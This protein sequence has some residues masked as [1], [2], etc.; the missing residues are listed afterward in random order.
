[1]PTAR[2]CKSPQ[3]MQLF[4]VFLLGRARLCAVNGRP[5]S[6]LTIWCGWKNCE[7]MLSARGRTSTVRTIV[8]FEQGVKFAGS[9]RAYSFHTVGTVIR[10]GWWALTLMSPRGNEQRNS[11][12]RC[13]PSSTLGV[14][15]YSRQLVRSPPTPKDASSS[16]DDFVAALDSRIRSMASTH[17]LLSSS[18]WQGVPLR[19]LLQRELAPYT[20]NSNTCIDGPE[21]I[22]RPEAAQTTASVLHELTTNAAKYGALSKREGRVSVRWH[23]T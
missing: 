2:R 6:N 17:Q 15:T 9:T 16:M 14:R 18:R 13:V 12:E 21:V 3:A 11:N 8:S 1:M 22:L 20:S 7:T 5:V 19:E 4:T 10:S 23:C